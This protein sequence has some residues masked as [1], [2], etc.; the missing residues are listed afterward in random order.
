MSA[1]N[2]RK[3][4]SGAVIFSD[5]AGLRFTR[6]FDR[7]PCILAMLLTDLMHFAHAQGVDFESCIELARQRYDEDTGLIRDAG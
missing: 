6:C 2:F 4:E 1:T 5:Y 7:V 3:A